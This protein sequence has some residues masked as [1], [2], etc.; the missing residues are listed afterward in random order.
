MDVLP[1]AA[2]IGAHPPRPCGGP[3]GPFF[4]TP[5]ISGICRW[6]PSRFGTRMTGLRSAVWVC[7]GAEGLVATVQFGVEI[8][9][10]QKVVG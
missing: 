7:P 6:H 5:Q 10:R 9:G 2:A 1:G 3:L 4:S 8:A